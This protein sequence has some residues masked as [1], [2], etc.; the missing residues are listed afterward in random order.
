[1][2]YKVTGSMQFTVEMVINADSEEEAEEIAMDKMDDG[3]LDGYS[4]V[5]PTCDNE[6]VD[7]E[8]INEVTP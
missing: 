1:M 3:S 8:L 4:L 7:I 6:V 5:E 2:K